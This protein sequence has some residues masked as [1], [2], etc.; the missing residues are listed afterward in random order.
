M[1]FFK[2]IKDTH[3]KFCLDQ[4]R[5][6][7]TT[8]LKIARHRNHL[9]FNLHCKHNSVI[10]TSVRL[11]SSVK[12][13]KAESVLRRAEKCLLNVRISQTIGKLNK[14]EK[15]KT[16]LSETVYG[17]DSPLPE[18][19][20]TEI[21]RHHESAQQREHDLVKQRQQ[22]KYKRLIEKNTDTS[23]PSLASECITRW[24]KNCSQRL[25]S[26]P[27]LSVLAKGLNFAITPPKVPVINILTETESAASRLP[28]CEG[29]LL[30]AKVATLLEKPATPKS[31]IPVHERE[32]LRNL[33]S[34]ESIQILPAD[35]GRCTVILDK[36]E[37][38]QKCLTLLSDTKTYKRL[39]K[40][41]P[42]SGY[43]D[44][45]VEIL[46]LIQTEGQ[47]DQKE[48]FSV[49]PTTENPPKFYGLPKIHKE[50][51]PLRP[52]VSSCGSITH[53]SSKLLSK[54]LGPLVGK[55]DHH[56]LN[57]KEFVKKVK[58][59]RIEEDEVIVS[60]DVVSLFTSVPVD[61]AITII[62]QRLLS[63]PTLAERTKISVNNIV[64]LLSFVLNTTY[65]V[66]DGVYYKQI[67]GA[68]MGS[69]VSP[70]VC[71]L[72]MEDFEQRAIASALNPPSWWFRYVDDTHSKQKRKNVDNFTD[73]LNSI[74]KDIQFTKEL[75]DPTSG[76]LAFLDTETGIVSESDRSIKV[77]V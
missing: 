71:N 29:S 53:P 63:D 49:Y 3:G 26:D 73:H 34:D 10:P 25:L 14:L 66:Y 46:T 6:L 20:K 32:A 16:R 70:I 24:V 74:D 39:G 61:R 77:R 19:T 9:R 17:E 22:D 47:I 67:H 59:E 51:R 28:A 31:N 56:V 64:S 72:F 27:E 55:T 13:K 33:R 43:K 15:D 48:Y 23:K 8:G 68:A 1:S 62:H 41:N 50:G 18:D 44:K 69:P 4:I 65:F 38:H 60:Y 57:S 76:D 37:Y 52:I 7:E 12:G 45:L 2:H 75:P 35:K 40:R 42:T 54:I 11:T 30:R 5:L 21:K 58:D 36:E